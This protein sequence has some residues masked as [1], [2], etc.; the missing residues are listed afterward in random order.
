MGSVYARG[1]QEPGCAATL[2]DVSDPRPRRRPWTV[3][4]LGILCA[5]LLVALGIVGY[6]ALGPSRPGPAGSDTPTGAPSDPPPDPETQAQDQLTAHL[7]HCTAPADTIPAHCGIRL[8]W[9]ADLRTPTE[10]RYRA[11]RMPALTLSGDS[12]RATGGE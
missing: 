10:F 7:Q 1:V 5:A 11:E 2:N 6:L 12:F 4:S 3:V 9:A 8:P